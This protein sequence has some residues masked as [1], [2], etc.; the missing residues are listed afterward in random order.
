MLRIALYLT[1][2]ALLTAPTLAQ[3]WVATR[4]RGAVELKTGTQWRTLARG[5]VIA[6]GNSVRTGADGKVDLARG[7]ELIALA[8]GTEIVL[9]ESAGKRTSLVQ[10]AGVLTVDVERRNVQHFSVQTPF[11]AA[12]VK[13]T[14]FTVTVGNDA[15]NV[16]VDRGIVQVQDT[17]HDLVVDVRPGQE[18][19][20]SQS[21]PLQVAGPGSIA[22]FNFDGVRIVNGTSD[23][24]AGNDGTPTSS[25]AENT[26]FTSNGNGIGNSGSTGSS[27]R[28]GGKDDNNGNINGDVGTV[29]SVSSGDE[30]DANDDND[31][32]NEGDEGDQNDQNDDGDDGDDE[33]DEDEDDN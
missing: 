24:P 29:K 33:D 30:D 13:G 26:N 23:V 6:H 4:L 8:P 5:D 17:V 3:E 32:N 10:M 12:V 16:E 21:T 22:V 15:T 25:R 27:N 19:Q 9:H 18:A 7:A 2:V 14:K 11:L 20:V 31:Q 28:A 1:M